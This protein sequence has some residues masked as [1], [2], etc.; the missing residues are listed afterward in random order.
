VGEAGLG[1][2]GIRRHRLM[3]SLA[4]TRPA[5]PRGS[6]AGWMLMIP[7]PITHAIH[8]DWP[9]QQGFMVPGQGQGRSIR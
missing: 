2:V 6:S 3:H 9:P 7:A 4:H 5:E 8:L 1:G